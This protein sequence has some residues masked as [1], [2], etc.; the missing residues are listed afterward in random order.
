MKT[1]TLNA[2]KKKLL[3]KEE[4]REV[5]EAAARDLIEMDLADL[6]ESLGIT[7]VELAEK[8]ERRQP[9]LSSMEN[10]GDH[11]LSTL[12]SYV[13][14]LGGELKLVAIVN[15]KTIRLAL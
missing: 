6:R 4:I 15:G 1:T 10:A 14:A 2:L 3:T 7:Q 5:N 11:R 13:R 8:L 9:A 12:R